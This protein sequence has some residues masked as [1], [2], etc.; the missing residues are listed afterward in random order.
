MVRVTTTGPR[1]PV[2]VTVQVSNTGQLISTSPIAVQT[3]PIITE[4]TGGG[5]S[6]LDLLTDV[7]ATGEEAGAVPVYD[8]D[9]DEY[10]IEKL[11]VSDLSGPVDGGTY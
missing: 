6:R 8:P 7:D 1:K 11:E 5:V 9:T 3:L 2:K 4:T 10:V